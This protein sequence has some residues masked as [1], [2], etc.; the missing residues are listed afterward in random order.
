MPGLYS[1]LEINSDIICA[2]ICAFIPS[3]TAF[4]C[5]FSHRTLRVSRPPLTGNFPTCLVVPKPHF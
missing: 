4:L 1:L 3:Q 5:L 2:D